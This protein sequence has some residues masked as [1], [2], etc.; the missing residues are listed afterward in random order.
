MIGFRLTDIEFDDDLIQETLDRAEFR[1]LRRTGFQT[2]EKAQ[3]SLQ[4]S[5]LISRP[6]RPP[7]SHTGF[8]SRFILF[9]VDKNAKSMVVGPKQLNRRSSNVTQALEKSGFSRNTR[10]KLI[11]IAARPFMVPAFN[12]IVRQSVPDVFANTFGKES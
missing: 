10:G 7:N 2:R 5:N 4:H 1:G 3:G 12:Q 11:R 8:L 6:G 9:D